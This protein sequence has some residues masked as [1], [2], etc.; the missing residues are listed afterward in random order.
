MLLMKTPVPLAT[1]GERVVGDGDREA[2]LLGKELVDAADERAA[3]GHHETAVDEVGG[4]FGRAAFER[5]AHGLDDGADG[6]AHGLAD[7]LG[8]DVDRLGQAGHGVAALD[9]HRQLGLERVGGAD[10]HL[11]L[12]RR[13]L[14]DQQVVGALHVVDDGEVDLV[15][16]HADGFRKDDAVERNDGDLGRAAADV[17]D[18]VGRGFVDGET[19]AERG[20]ERFGDGVHLARAGVGGGLHHGALLDLGDAAGIAMQTLGWG[21]V[22]PPL[23]LRMK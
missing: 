21:K 22:F 11:D 12:F 6:V 13:A 14:A 7:F 5:D 9:L 16:R 20:G 3:A 19:D 23:A 18:H 4:K 17:D 15:A 8:S 2:G 10:G 1:R